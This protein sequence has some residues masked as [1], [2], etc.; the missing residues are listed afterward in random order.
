MSLL[1]LK[2]TQRSLRRTFLFRN[3]ILL[4]FQ[5]KIL[6]SFQNKFLLPFSKQKILSSF[7]SCVFLS[8]LPP[9]FLL[10]IFHFSFSSLFFSLFSSLTASFSVTFERKKSKKVANR[11]KIINFAPRIVRNAQKKD[12]NN[13]KRVGHKSHHNVKSKRGRSVCKDNLNEAKLRN[14]LMKRS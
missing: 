10:F 14:Y 13:C 11:Q 5:N 8:V 9:V 12:N 6:L 2:P 1:S 7:L 3:K 4:P